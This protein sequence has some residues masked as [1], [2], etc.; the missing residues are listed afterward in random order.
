MSIFAVFKA[1]IFLRHCDADAF[2]SHMIAC[3][4]IDHRVCR[5]Y[6]VPGTGRWT[7][8]I[9]AMMIGK[10]AYYSNKYQ[11]TRL[12]ILLLYTCV[13]TRLR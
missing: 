3:I 7:G 10:I 13:D 11:T 1:M 8:G 9:A 2:C 5:I 4:L 12:P 6:T